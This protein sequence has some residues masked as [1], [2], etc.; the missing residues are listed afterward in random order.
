VGG[1]WTATAATRTVPDPLTGKPF[2]VVP[3]TASSEIRPFVDSL[4]S[5]PKSGLHNPLKNPER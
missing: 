5:V 2:L 1:N 3:E 4:L